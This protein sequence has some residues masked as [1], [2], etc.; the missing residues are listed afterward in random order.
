MRALRVNES[1]HSSEN[2]FPVDVLALLGEKESKCDQ[3]T[4]VWGS[5][6][7]FDLSLDPK[8][9]KYTYMGSSRLI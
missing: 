1:K 9:P 5:L 7:K 4:L 2:P 6:Q 3:R 8:P